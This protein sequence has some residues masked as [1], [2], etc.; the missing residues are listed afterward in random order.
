MGEFRQNLLGKKFCCVLFELSRKFQ[1]QAACIFTRNLLRNSQKSSYFHGNFSLEKSPTKLTRQ[2]K[3]TLSFFIV[4]PKKKS[5]MYFVL[6]CACITYCEMVI[7]VMSPIPTLHS[8]TLILLVLFFYHHFFLFQLLLNFS[9]YRFFICFCV[10]CMLYSCL[11]INFTEAFAFLSSISET[12]YLFYYFL[13]FSVRKSLLFYFQNWLLLLLPL[14]AAVHAHR[15]TY[16]ILCYLRMRRRKKKLGMK[17]T[18]TVEGK[19][20]RERNER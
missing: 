4:L 6:F 14:A 20:G 5:S 18:W 19:F 16:F 9:F 17:I 7:R 12:F 3:S 11:V 10:L 2:P 15:K 13:F 8:L 1:Q